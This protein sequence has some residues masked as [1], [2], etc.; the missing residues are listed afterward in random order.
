MRGKKIKRTAALLIALFL[1]FP[2]AGISAFAQTEITTEIGSGEGVG[3]GITELTYDQFFLS[4]S[5]TDAM[6]HG[7]GFQGAQIRT[8]QGK[9]GFRFVSLV[10]KD[11]LTDEALAAAG[12]VSAE[13]GTLLIPAAALNGGALTLETVTQ[14]VAYQSD[15]IYAAKVKSTVTME[16]GVA[17]NKFVATIVGEGITSGSARPI[18]NMDFA[19]RPYLIYK[20]ADGQSVQVLYGTQAARSMQQVAQALDLTGYSGHAL[21]YLTAVRGN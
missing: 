13:Y 20:D 4:A 18:Y 11:K 2:M 15:T 14:G 19:V 10:Y 12:A 6:E 9:E 5:Q 17:F 3:K 21:E 7:V 8:T 1:V 16:E